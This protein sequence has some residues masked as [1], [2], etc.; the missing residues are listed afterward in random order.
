MAK[1]KVKVLNAHVD[2]KGPGSVIEVD[3]KTADMLV[4][5]GYAE[6]VKEAK[7]QEAPKED[8]KEDKDK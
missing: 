4:K 1:K 2:G 3:G 5:N 8:V 6:H 7:K